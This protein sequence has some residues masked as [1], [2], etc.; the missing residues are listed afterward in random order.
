MAAYLLEQSIPLAANDTAPLLDAIYWLEV[1]L[2]LEL[3]FIRAPDAPPSPP[4]AL[5]KN[6]GLA[7]A[8]LV[9]SKSVVEGGAFGEFELPL[10]VDVFP[11]LMLGD[12]L[13]N[14][15]VDTK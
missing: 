4:T 15:P 5:L 8:H 12:S 9:Q 11:T 3:S 13:V 6:A 14:W 10:S 2:R 1:S 7:H